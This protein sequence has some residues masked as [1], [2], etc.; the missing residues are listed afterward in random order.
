MPGKQSRN[1]IVSER[2]QI[3]IALSQF[4]LDTELQ[5]YDFK[6]IAKIILE[7][8]YSLDEVKEINKYE[9]FPV[10][11]RN[12][13]SVAGEWAGFDEEWLVKEILQAV[14]NRNTPKKVGNEI[15]YKTFNMIDDDWTKLELVY[16]QMKAESRFKQ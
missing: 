11:H 8:P 13:Q 1:K 16:K 10:L 9:V 15:A 3:W 6:Y 5:D 12:L 7:S 4:Y 14:E 2:K